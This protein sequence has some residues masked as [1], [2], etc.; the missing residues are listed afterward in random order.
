MSDENLLI[1]PTEKEVTDSPLE[2]MALSATKHIG[3]LPSLVLHSI[4]FVGIFSL[5]W[6]GVS[7]NQI[8]LVLTTVVSLEAIYLAIFIQMTVNRQAH[9]IEEVSED[10]DEIQEDVED[11]QEEAKEISEDVEYIQE[12]VEDIKEDV[13]ELSDE[14]GGAEEGDGS[15]KMSETE[16][17]QR[18]EQMLEE[19]LREIKAIKI[20]AQ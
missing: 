9:Q 3:S 19:M 16:R 13:E 1:K 10:I 7:F 12:D 4:F 11:I 6:F 5:Q 18:V 20:H 15:E 17:K 2:R 14:S 8:M